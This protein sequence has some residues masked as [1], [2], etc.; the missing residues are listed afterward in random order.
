MNHLETERLILREWRPEDLA[1]MYA[2]NQDPRV[3]EHYPGLKTLKETEDFI[4]IVK[5]HFSKYGYG[6]YAV[7]VKNQSPFIG[8]VGLNHVAFTAPFTP[9]VEIGWRLAADEWGKGYATEAAR[10]VLNEAFNQ[11]GLKEVVAFT[12]VDNTRSRHVMEKLGFA[13][14][15]EGDFDHPFVPKEHRVCRHVLY[16]L[17]GPGH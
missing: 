8:F 3:M 4:N 2:L 6:M 9:A 1:G 7:E 12:A 13:H 11:L 5:A 16:R 10:C 15:S 17:K 14:D